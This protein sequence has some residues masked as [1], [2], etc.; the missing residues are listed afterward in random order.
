MPA[1]K[2]VDVPRYRGKDGWYGRLYHGSGGG[3]NAAGIYASLLVNVYLA[4]MS[5]EDL[6]RILDRPL[7][8]GNGHSGWDDQRGWIHY[9]VGKDPNWAE[10]SLAND[11]ARARASLAALE[12]QPD[13]GKGPSRKDAMG[14]GAAGRLVN[15][16]TGGVT[17]LWHGQLLLAR[18][19]YFDP[20]RKRPGISEDCAALVESM[21]DDSA[22]LVLVNTSADKAH[23]VLVQAGAYA[24]HQCISVTPEGGKAVEVNGPLF[25]VKLAPGAGQRLVVTMKRYANPPTARLPWVGGD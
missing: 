12:K 2:A 20:E 4:T 18:F 9:L 6:Q 14:C 7:D 5:R 11:L 19:R 21:A 22:T 1:G 16:M 13:C 3:E 10:R 15:C 24:E 25:A 23:T 17:P 8:G